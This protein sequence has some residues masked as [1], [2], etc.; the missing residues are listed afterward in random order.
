MPSNRGHHGNETARSDHRDPD[1]SPAGRTRT[2]GARP[3]HGLNLSCTSD[4]RRGLVRILPHLSRRIRTTGEEGRLPPAHAW[5]TTVTSVVA[6]S[7][8]AYESDLRHSGYSRPI[9][10]AQSGPCQYTRPL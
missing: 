2:F 4:P 3:P 10:S 7:A 8:V 6:G 9:W 5:N 1:R